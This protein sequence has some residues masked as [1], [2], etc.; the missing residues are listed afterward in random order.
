VPKYR[1]ICRNSNS[2][3]TDPLHHF[4]SDNDN[5]AIEHADKVRNDRTCELWRAYRVVARWEHGTR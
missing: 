1:L 3:R 2:G 4:D 5:A